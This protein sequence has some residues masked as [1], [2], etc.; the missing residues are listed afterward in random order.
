MQ[1]FG[2]YFETNAAAHEPFRPLRHIIHAKFGIA[3]VLFHKILYNISVQTRKIHGRT[4]HM[5]RILSFFLCAAMLFG[6]TGVCADSARGSAPLALKDTSKLTLIEDSAYVSRIPLGM[7]AAELAS[8]FVSDGVTVSLGSTE[9]GDADKVSSGCTVTLNGESLTCAVTGDTVGNGK[10]DLPDVIGILKYIAGWEP[11]IHVPAADADLNGKVELEDA[12]LLLKY[13]ADWDIRIGVFDVT[14]SEERLVAEHED[15]TLALSVLDN[16]QKLDRRSTDIGTSATLRMSMAKNEIESCQIYLASEN[17][18]SDLSIAFTPF[19][20]GVGGSL[21][22]EMTMHHYVSTESVKNPNYKVQFPDAMIP[23]SQFDIKDGYSQGFLL[24]AKAG[25]DAEAGLYESKVTVT[26][27]DGEVVKV[28]KVY[29]EVWD[30]ALPDESSCATAFGLSWYTVYTTHKLYEGDDA[31]LYKNYY[32]YMLE[33]RISAYH[34]PYDFNDPRVDEYINDPR[35]SSF[36]V[37]GCQAIFDQLTDDEIS[38]LY[39]KYGDNE[40]WKKKAYFYYVDEPSNQSQ[41]TELKYAHNRLERLFPGSRHVTPICSNPWYG[42]RDQVEV[43]S[44]LTNL[45]CPIS[46]FFADRSLVNG[47]FFSTVRATSLGVDSVNKYGIGADRFAAYKDAGDELWWY[48]CVL[49]QAPFA[50][51]FTNYQGEASRALFWQQYMFGVDGCLYWAVNYWDG[52]EWRTSDN[53][54]Y[55]GDGLLIYSGY[56]F[57]INGPIGSI[58]MEYIRDGI[59]DFEYLTMAEKLCGKEAVNEILSTVTT[60]I[61]KYTD[62]SKVIEAAKSELAKLI[63]SAEK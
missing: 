30:M 19:E 42:E 41:I 28:A 54:F 10:I 40:N 15:E 45:W 6:V 13:I 50:N 16:M 9:L 63:M 27:A 14:Y 22:T 21:E 8:Q 4:K 53:D 24:K 48:V 55:S 51:F 46:S 26:N 5:R 37:D 44:E 61:T 58:R 59:E 25:K 2:K 56:R 23:L 34:M 36:C 43:V 29:A 39:E 1:H 47:I 17:G 52:S 49:P 3:L 33:N 12:S 57:G 62:D 60:G 11:D 7:T 20:N 35:V 18:H 38:G 31:Q 32:E